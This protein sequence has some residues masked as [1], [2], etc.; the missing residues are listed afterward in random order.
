MNQDVKAMAQ[1][2]CNAEEA[3]DL[4]VLSQLLDAL[5]EASDPRHALFQRAV[6]KF[7]VEVFSAETNREAAEA[8][9]NFPAHVVSRQFFFETTT[10]LTLLKGEV[11]YL[12]WPELSQFG[13]AKDLHRAQSIFHLSRPWPQ[14]PTPEGVVMV[15]AAFDEMGEVLGEGPNSP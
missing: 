7:V 13:A 15:E 5:E 3:A 12:F 1:A 14:V 9:A 8:T 10:A 6:A 11:L 2:V 4:D